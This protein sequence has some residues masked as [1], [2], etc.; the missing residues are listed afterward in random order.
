MKKYTLIFVVLLCFQ[1]SQGCINLKIDLPPDPGWGIEYFIISNYLDHDNNYEKI[2]KSVKVKTTDEYVYSII[3]VLN[4]EKRVDISWVWYGPDKK[5]V[6][7]SSETVVNSNS[8]FLEYFVI[9][10][11]LERSLFHKKRGKW[12]VSVLVNGEFFSYK[13]FVIH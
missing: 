2:L 11:S 1:L 9:W 6:K 5:I 13:K 10:D 7:K 4:I 8:N 12:S 3:K